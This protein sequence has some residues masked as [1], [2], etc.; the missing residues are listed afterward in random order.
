MSYK[1]TLAVPHH[2]PEGFSLTKW[3]SMFPQIE[4]L[5]GVVVAD[6]SPETDDEVSAFLSTN[7]ALVGVNDRGWSPEGIVLAGRFRRNLMALAL[8]TDADFMMYCDGD[9]LLHWLDHYPDELAAVVKQIPDYDFTV[10]GRTERAFRSHP[11]VQYYTE[12]IIN[13]VFGRISGHKWDVTAAARG[14]SRTAAQVIVDQSTDDTFGNDASWPLLIQRVG[15][16]TM[17]EIKTEGLEYE[18][19]EKY[20]EASENVGGEAQWTAQIDSNPRHWIHRLN[21]ARIEVESILPYA[22]SESQ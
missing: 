2:D 22:N 15:G 4:A 14:L 7:C 6:V 5:F 13:Q 11:D 18:T 20:A 17:T 8:R 16:L 12:G 1:I 19:A 10:L 21:L 9:R 3:Q